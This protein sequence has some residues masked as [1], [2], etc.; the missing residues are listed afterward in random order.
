MVSWKM[1][2]LNDRGVAQILKTPKN[3]IYMHKNIMSRHE[4]RNF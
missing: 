1:M 4:M 3:Y 2:I